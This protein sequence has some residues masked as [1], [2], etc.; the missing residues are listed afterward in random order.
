M[1]PIE[2]ILS[3]LT[4]LSTILLLLPDVS[5]KLKYRVAPLLLIL[6]A[7]AQIFFEGFRWQLWP[8]MIAISLLLL[9]AVT[10]ST[11]QPKG[12]PT[13]IAIFSLILAILSLAGGWLLPI[14]K[15]F[16]TTGPYEVGTTV[17]PLAD[18]SRK[19]LYATDTDQPRELMVQVWYPANPGEEGLRAQWMPDIAVAGPAIA[20]WVDLPSFALNHLKYA[21]VNAYLDI[22]IA[23][24]SENFPLL[25]FSHGW[26]GFKEQNIYQVEELASHGYV[27]VGISHTY[28]AVLTV[29]PDG[30]EI[31]RNDAALPSGVSQEV[32]DRASNQLVR[33]WAGDIG[34]VLDEFS[35]RDQAGDWLFADK[36]DLSKVGIFGHSTGGGAAAEFCGIDNRCDAA[37]MMDLWVEPVSDEIV[38]GGLTQPTLLM[39]SADWV[40]LDN[41]SRNFLWI[42]EL[43]GAS[44]GEVTE[45]RIKGTEHY[46]FTS[47]PLFT[48]LAN[49]IGL[50]GP[51]PGNSGLELIN[52]YTVAFFDQYLRGDDQGLLLSENS[53]FEAAQFIQQP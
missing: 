26:S 13:A 19:E 2:L 15:P 44:N 18:T 17:F 31:P 48:P 7:A 28:G 6:T 49:A 8:L 46:D 9:A 16:P 30:R 21:K 51:I 25:I 24:D 39:H 20:A 53:Q 36:L 27:V 45:F 33:Q 3:L 38:T 34:F 47:V 5:T 37:L 4:F 23:S 11:Q 52:F 40:D 42:G 41:P 29:F 43:V 22:P 14:P 1:R 32:Y 12:K 50:K 35:R 10:R